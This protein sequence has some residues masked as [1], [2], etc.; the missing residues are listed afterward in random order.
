MIAHMPWERTSNF[1]LFLSYP[2]MTE[3]MSTVSTVT[4]HNTFFMDYCKYIWSLSTYIPA[5][6]CDGSIQESIFHFK[7]IK[8]SLTHYFPF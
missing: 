6:S 1:Q 8:N 3:T 7:Y 5:L 2:H 4:K